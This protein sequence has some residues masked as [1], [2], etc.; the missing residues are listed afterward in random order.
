MFQQ[1]L[2]TEETVKVYAFKPPSL[3]KRGWGRFKLLNKALNIN[4]L[5][6][7]KSPSIPLLQRGKKKVEYFHSL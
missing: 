4:T 3:A 5:F 2:R 6:F 1:E 7:I